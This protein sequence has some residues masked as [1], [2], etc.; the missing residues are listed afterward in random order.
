MAGCCDN[1]TLIDGGD[2]FK[3][4][5]GLKGDDGTT[6]YPHVSADGTLSWTNNGGL[7]NPDPVRIEG[8]DGKSAYEAA[9]EAG[10]TGTEEEFNETLA[11]I[12]D[13]DEALNSKAG[14]MTDTASGM[15]ATFVPDR[16]I[17]QDL[18]VKVS[19]DTPVQSGTGTPSPD[20][21]RPIAG[22]SS[23][24][25]NRSGENTSSPTAYTVNLAEPW[26]AGTL[27]ATGGT[28]ETTWD[29]ASN[30]DFSQFGVMSDSVSTTGYATWEWAEGVPFDADNIS[31][32][33]CD[34][35]TWGGKREI[36]CFCIEIESATEAALYF[37]LSGNMSKANWVA[38]MTQINPTFVIPLST[39]STATI[40]PVT[41]PVISSETNNVW[42]NA[43]PVEVTFAADLTEAI[44]GKQDAPSDAGVAGQVL[45]LDDDLNP[46]WLDQ[47][48]GGGGTSNYN[49]LTNKPRINGVI[50]SGDKSGAD[51]GLASASDIPTVPVQSVNGEIGAVVL[52]ASDV[53]A[54]AEP[55]TAGTAG[56]VLGLD[57][58]LNPTWVNQG[59]GGSSDYNAL[60]NKPQIEG[61]TLSGNKTASDLGLAKASDIPTVPV[62]SVNGKTGA[63]VL[64]ASDVGAK[65]SSYEAPV[66]SVNSKTGTVVLSA[67]DVGALPSSTAIPSKTSD[68]TNDSGFVNAAGAAAAAPV[69]SVNGNTGA[70]TVQS[71][72]T[73]SGILKGAGSGSISAA[74]LGTDYGNLAFTVTLTAAGWSNN[75][76]T[77][78]N[79]NFIASGFAYI[80]TPA[81]TSIKNYGA[82]E[83]YADNVT[84]AGQM[85]FHCTTVPSSDLT[86]NILRG[87]S[88]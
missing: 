7:P 61:V 6:F 18:G 19:I 51:L 27:D 37:T 82:A 74:T 85:T 3:A 25:I 14:S 58:N 8:A 49:N 44:S 17:T 39:P 62:Q 66:S 40:T 43:G 32:S 20:N 86:V 2:E 12:G 13:V 77:V 68:L 48:G 30:L 33:I 26:Y 54:V 52:D 1:F 59:G 29:Y 11:N 67:S 41:I 31:S 84:V 42:S 73:S 22:W 5:P 34:S 79:A 80:V 55:Q 63:V 75:A 71:T 69:Q 38:R 16:T 57:S 24:Q 88:A 45:G 76:Q 65:P 47:G 10:Y 23:V 78:S 83:I 36:N 53:G 15:V 81:G 46:V 87:V 28:L 21:V 9:V 70:V 50:L 60:S 35:F 56:Q 72:I 4:F 64:S